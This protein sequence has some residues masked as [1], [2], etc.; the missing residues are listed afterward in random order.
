VANF[1]KFRGSVCQIPQLTAAKFP[2]FV[3]YRGILFMK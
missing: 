2:N 1:S 3:A